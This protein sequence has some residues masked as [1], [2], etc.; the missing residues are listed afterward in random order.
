MSYFGQQP[1][2]ALL[3]LLSGQNLNDIADKSAARNNLDVYSKSETILNSTPIG[4]IIAY[5]GNVAPGGYL[6]CSGQTI[7]ASTY[8]DL[9]AFLGGGSSRVVPDLR[10]EFLRGWDNGRGVDASRTNK[11]AQADELRSHTHVNT[12]AIM[13]NLT[14]GTGSNAWSEGGSQGQITQTG[15]A[16]GV[17]TRPRN[18]SVLYCIKAYGSISDVAIANTS[19]VLS[20]VSTAAQISQFETVQA[21]NGYQKLPN[22][23]ILQWG[24]TASL[25]YSVASVINYPIAFP[26]A[27]FM[28]AVQSETLP[29]A[30]S[31][32]PYFAKTSLSTFTTTNPDNVARVF[33]WFAI[34]Y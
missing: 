17:E 22:G 31:G 8:P 20:L 4:T 10:G 16:G 27:V 23:L 12:P 6:P 9:V 5:W 26:N 24:R 14:Y 29:S 1:L 30:P 2:S 15:F 21:Q 11:S 13:L 18:I 19:G 28:G 33:Q 7:N 3:P 34:G 25:T 32:M